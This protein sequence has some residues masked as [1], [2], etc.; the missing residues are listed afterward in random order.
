MEGAKI[1]EL[2]KSIKE[3]KSLSKEIPAYLHN[4]NTRDVNYLKKIFNI[5]E[6]MEVPVKINHGKA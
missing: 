6:K 4:L 2:D 1:M 3:L 5:I